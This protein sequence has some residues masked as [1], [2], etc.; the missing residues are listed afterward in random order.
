MKLQTT[1]DIVIDLRIK[2]HL[3]FKAQDIHYPTDPILRVAYALV[4]L[5]TCQHSVINIG[6]Q[7]AAV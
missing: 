6:R 1:V 7:S 4:A 3:P 5:R 2:Q